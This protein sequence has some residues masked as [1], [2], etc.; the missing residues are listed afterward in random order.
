M[1]TKIED[2]NA[3]RHTLRHPMDNNQYVFYMKWALHKY[4]SNDTLEGDRA[5]CMLFILYALVNSMKYTA[6][7]YL[8]NIYAFQYLFLQ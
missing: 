6:H 4:T 8:G 5:M 7:Y 2:P 1:A 3:L